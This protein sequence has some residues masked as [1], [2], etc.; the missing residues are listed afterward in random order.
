M[1]G[2]PRLAITL[3]AG[4]LGCGS[5]PPPEPSAPET[6]APPERSGAQDESL[7]RLF[8]AVVEGHLCETLGGHY[9]GLPEEG[10]PSGPAAGAAPVGG[11]LRVERCRA[12]RTGDTVAL[13][14][15]GIGWS[16]LSEREEGPM[17]SAFVVR[18]SL[19]F[20]ATVT[21]EGPVDVAYVEDRRL[22]SLY[23]TPSRVP[24][25]SLVPIGAIPVAPEGGWSR[26]VGNLGDLFGDSPEE[27]A[28]PRVEEEGSARFRDR[29]KSG[30][31]ITVDLCRGQMDPFVGALAPG[32]VPERP[33]PEDGLPWT[34]NR[35]VRLHPE[36]LD[37][38]GPFPGHLAV[39]LVG[40]EG[41]ATM[42]ARCAEDATAT[43]AAF[44]AGRTESE[45]ET[46]EG[47]E[48]EPPLARA[49]FRAGDR[50][51]LE[52]RADCD[53]VLLTRPDEATSLHRYRVRAPG[54]EPHGLVPCP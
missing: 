29:L 35:R 45:G 10:S 30:F 52:V 43:V 54:A 33:F 21:L 41:A 20:E 18:G 31:T 23:L 49:S 36:G 3:A 16:F 46:S 14:L 7:R 2:S 34:D 5:A 13:H 19:P 1:G 15:E 28:R 9:L 17:G 6:V 4:L 39:E 40:E 48:T 24:E 38:A 50:T 27:R 8:A 51:L 47:P 44:L 37:A 53:V 11:R 25:A 12:T 22:L 32:E 26:F 42:E